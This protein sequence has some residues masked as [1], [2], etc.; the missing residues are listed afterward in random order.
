MSLDGIVYFPQ[1]FATSEFLETMLNRKN[2]QLR[3]LNQK[4]RVSAI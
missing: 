4:R 1:E 3:L 2:R